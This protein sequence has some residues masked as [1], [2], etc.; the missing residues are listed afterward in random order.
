M[1]KNL[2]TV[3]LLLMQILQIHSQTT[4]DYL[5]RPGLTIAS[6]HYNWVGGTFINTYKFVGDTLLCGENLLIY[7]PA[8]PVHL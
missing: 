7:Q 8:P 2:F 5:S 3:G 4:Y 1:K 6:V